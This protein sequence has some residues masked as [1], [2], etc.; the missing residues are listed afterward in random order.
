MIA[1]T[2]QQENQQQTTAETAGDQPTEASAK[3]VC[4]YC[5]KTFSRLS[6]LS[7]HLC[8]TKRRWQQEHDTGV[9]LGFRTFLKFYE[10]TQNKAKVK[11]YADFVASP[12][13]SAFVK[14]GNYL[15]QINAVNPDAFTKYLI[16]NNKRLDHW[17]KDAF[18]DEYLINYI[19]REHPQDAIERALKEMQRWAD[20]NNSVF[21]HYF[22]YAN[23]NKVC[24][25]INNGRVSPWVIFNCDS[26]IAFLE[27]LNNDQLE[28]IYNIIDPAFWQ[29]KFSTYQTD[30][31]WVKDILKQAKL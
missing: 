4:K 13:Y 18:Y 19:R 2:E 27:S 17:T 3:H 30:T 9:R 20:E 25:H 28:I 5:K 6:T 29:T 14:F 22:K 16:D 11:T 12:Y 24:Y 15:V 8:E 26:G 7:A 31:Q 1:K 10:M 23:P 21:N